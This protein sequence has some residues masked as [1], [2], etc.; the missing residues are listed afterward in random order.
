MAESDCEQLGS[1]WLAQPANA[2]SC[3]A[4]VAVG[5]W[6]LLFVR[7]GRAGR[8]GLIAG[9]VALVGTGLGSFAYHGPQPDWAHLAHDG[10]ALAL[11]VVVVGRMTC[12]LVALSTRSQAVSAV[13]SVLP[14]AALAITAYVAGRSGSPLCHPATIWQPHAAWHVLCAV[15][16]GIAVRRV[17][18]PAASATGAS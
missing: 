9:G 5:S 1:A 12:Q 4:F 13:K 2:V 15:T 18:E 3:L 14:W 17:E 16:I 11:A 8:G 7:H 10:S 6:L